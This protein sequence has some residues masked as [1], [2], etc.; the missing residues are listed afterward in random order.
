MMSLSDK[1]TK[2]IKT[3]KSFLILGMGFFGAELAEQ[4]YKLG[5][6]VIGVDTDPQIVASMADKLTQAIELN[7]ADEQALESLGIPEF[8]VCVIARGSNLEDSVSIAISLK[9]LGA[10]RIIGRT[11]RRKHAE[12]LKKLGVEET[13]FPEIEIADYIAEKLVRP[14]IHDK[15]IFNN[16]VVIEALIVFDNMQGLLVKEFQKRIPRGVTLLGIQRGDNYIND[17]SDDITLQKD[18]FIIV[19]GKSEKI[20]EIE[21]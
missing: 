15:I 18:D 12:I 16:D 19:W 20:R 9:E 2:P 21:K 6:E 3:N 17:Y 13:I 5:A 1:K 4:L 11:V 8:D 7:P 10:K 14:R